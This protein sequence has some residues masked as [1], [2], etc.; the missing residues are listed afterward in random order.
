MRILIVLLTFAAAHV[1]AQPYGANDRPAPTTRAGHGS[2]Q[3]EPEHRTRARE[4]A[5][6]GGQLVNCDPAGC[7]DTSGNRY[8]R[9]AGGNFYRQDGRFCQAQGQGRARCD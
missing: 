9:A 1:A 3:S 4:Q 7:W 5:R 2:Q 8:N 6:N